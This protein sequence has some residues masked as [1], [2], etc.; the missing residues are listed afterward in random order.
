MG[1]CSPEEC[2][3][4]SYSGIESRISLG[5]DM[6]CVCCIGFDFAGMGRRD[7]G[8]VGECFVS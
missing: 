8:D 2:S 6:D 5:V 3:A 1:R 7:V 4:S